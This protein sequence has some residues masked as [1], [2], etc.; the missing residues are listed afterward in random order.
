MTGPQQTALTLVDVNTIVDGYVTDPLFAAHLH[1]A[2]QQVMSRATALN[3]PY[4]LIVLSH[5]IGH[6]YGNDCDSYGHCGD[7]MFAIGTA[8]LEHADP[9]VLTELIKA[10]WVT[11]GQG[12]VLTDILGDFTAA[13]SYSPSNIPDSWEHSFHWGREYVAYVAAGLD[14]LA[15]DMVTARI[16]HRHG[17]HLLGVSSVLLAQTWPRLVEVVT[18]LSKEGWGYPTAPKTRMADLA[19]RLL[20]FASEPVLAYDVHGTTLARWVRA[21][22][23]ERAVAL[24]RAG[25]SEDEPTA[26]L[27]NETLHVM[28]ALRA[29]T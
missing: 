5:L 27:D 25:I 13:V 26:T 29:T 9:N 17:A 10:F 21:E 12:L 14:H 2:H 15:E 3:V 28:A 18:D 4:P 7:N 8:M 11:R 24:G 20:P 23:P 22:G 16:P 19:A 6:E 1:D